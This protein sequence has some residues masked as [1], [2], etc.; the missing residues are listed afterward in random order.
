MADQ[1]FKEQEK[2]LDAA[3]K[4]LKKKKKAVIIRP[5]GFG[6]TWML[7]ELIKDYKK[8]LYL[9]PSA[10][11]RDTVVNRYYDCMYDDDVCGYVDDDGELIDPETI[12]T[13]IEM[14]HIE[15]CDLMTYSKL[16]HIED[17]VFDDMNYDLVIFD[18]C[19]RLGGAKTKL[20]TEKLFSA[21]SKDKTHFIGATATPTRMDTFDVVSYFFSDNMVYTY[22]LFDAISNSIL[23]KPNYCYMTYDFETDLRDAALSVGENPDDPNIRSIIDSS[24]IELSKIYGMPKILREI[25]DKYAVS[26]SYMKFIVFFCSKKHMAD[27]I[28]EVEG[29]FREAYPHHT[30]STLRI[31]STTKTEANNVSKLNDLIPQM[32]HIDLIACIDML[33]MGYHV[34]DQT[35]ILMYRGTKSSTIFT[36]QLGRAL[37]VGMNNS[38]I[39]FDIVDN[40][41]RKAAFKMMGNVRKRKRANRSKTS[42]QI[43]TRT[44]YSVSEKDNSTLVFE[45]TSGKIVES[46][47]H[48]DENK[49]VVDR[50]GNSST[51]VF[52]ENTGIIWYSYYENDPRK[53]VNA[54]TETCINAIGHEAEYR[55]LIA[56][57]MAEPLV[58]KCR[59]A[60]EL[61]FRSWCYQHNI[62]YPITKRQLKKLYDMDKDDFYNEFCALLRENKIDYPLDDVHALLEMGEDTDDVPL[63]ICAK[64]RNVSINQIL[65]LLGLNEHQ[66][67]TTTA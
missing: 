46:Q 26:T 47:Y 43:L 7:T 44:Y 41:H 58:Q 45:D 64:A 29:W 42:D 11:I 5:T 37:S 35:G 38:A 4:L 3:R 34:N 61:H 2:T 27:K 17:E 60:L 63:E 15:N 23:P 12:N 13:W 20:A 10:V 28:H 9:Y 65:D 6:K 21:L 18:E 32:N 59:Y 39:V 66:N 52:D 40:L 25:C 48:L 50:H 30:L 31:S 33:N 24:I 54:L 55:D 14:N 62:E 19:H 51:L 16:I 67:S 8:V 57:A 49:N 1:N 53:N 36:Q 22:T 56:K